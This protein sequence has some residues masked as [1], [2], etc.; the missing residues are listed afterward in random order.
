MN[1]LIRLTGAERGCLVLVSEDGNLEIRAARNFGSQSIAT[2]E[3]DL[4]DTVV[5]YVVK[6]GEPVVTTNAQSDPR[7]AR[8]ES[9]V[10]FSLLSI[11]CEPLRVRERVIGALYLDNRI[12]SGVFTDEDL[13]ALTAFT[14]E[15]AI[16]IENA[17]LY[18]STDHALAARVEELTTLQQIDRE[19]NA[20]L[21][22]ERV[23]DLTLCWALQAAG[24]DGGAVTILADDGTM[25]SVLCVGD[26]S[27]MEPGSHEA[28]L[29]MG[30][31]EPV[32][33]GTTRML[34]PMRW[35]GRTIGLLELERAGDGLFLPDHIE[36]GGRLA[37]HAAVAIE[38]ARLYAEV[39]QA[40]REKSG[41]VSFVAHELRTPMTSIR[42]YA[43]M[44]R[45][46][47]VGPLE[48][49][50]AEFLSTIVRNVERM[51][52]LVSDLQD[53]SRIETGQLRLDVKETPLSEALENALEATR[54]QIEARSQLLTLEVP[55]DLPLA[56]ADP[57]RLAQVLINLLGNAYRYTPD[58]G[59]IHVRA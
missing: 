26:C 48:P 34:V 30:S 27:P 20:S 8:Q 36:V 33:I 51:Q 21:D 32:T 42:G 52:I 25:R 3:L 12:R 59:Q 16:A 10:G 38:N 2:S 5:E 18:T 11:A 15:A 29:A 6:N 23:L 37:D 24:A 35:E 40:N 17:R 31:Q 19:L 41:F 47:I 9:V 7:F 13:P 56:Y 1:S 28:L 39:R 54:A 50:Q 44:L 22:Y 55:E 14:N 4:S 43:D 49:Q 57:A 45:T 58:G 53:V 46:G